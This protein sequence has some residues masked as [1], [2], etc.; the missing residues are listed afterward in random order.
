MGACS[1]ATLAYVIYTSGSTGRPKGVAGHAR[2]TS[3][4][5]SRRPSRWFGFGAERRLDAVP[6]LRLRLLG[7][8]DLGGAALRRPAGGR[9]VLGEPLAGGVPR[10]A[11]A[12]A[13]D[14]A[15]PD[16]V[17]V[18]P[19]HRRRTRSGAGRAAGAA[20]GDLRRRGAGAREPGALV[21]APRRRAAAAGQ[22]VR[23][24]RD[25]GARDLA[26]DHGG[27][28]WTAAGSADRP[29]DPGSRGRT[30]RPPRPA[31]ADR[32]A[33][34]DLRRR[35]GRGPRLSRPAGADG[36]ALR[37]GPVR[38]TPGARL[39]RSGDL[40]RLAA[41]RRAG[42]PGADRP[43]GEDPRLPH[44]AGG[45]RGGAERA[46]WRC[47]EAV[48]LAREDVRARR[49]WWPTSCPA[50]VAPDVRPELRG[51]PRRK[52]AGLHGAGGLRRAARPAADAP[53]A[54]WTGARCR[55]P[56]SRG[57]IWGSATSRPGPRTEEAP[58]GD[59]AAGAGGRAG[60][61]H[62][63]FFELGGDSILAIQIV[64][65]ANRRGCTSRPSSSSSIR[66]SRSW[67][68]WPEPCWRSPGSAGGGGTGALDADPRWFRTASRSASLEPGSAAGDPSG[69]LHRRVA[70]PL[71]GI[72]RAA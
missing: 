71:A 35:R 22:H 21:R 64:A 7:L 47:G 57:R 12:R 50:R 48:V 43:P 55:R 49:G 32:R 66:R 4:G 45:D 23:H 5:C 17:G 40:A 70:G 61:P 3:R 62:D 44:R 18:P 10:A 33:G 53:T 59:L 11:G 54:R 14:G 67:R 6:L 56:G 8:G 41:R 19:A 58:G 65:Q 13:G 30:A 26:A 29:A 68:L 27:R 46:S 60:R 28:T 38:R 31:G 16:A 2:A 15:Q 24:H 36:G 1:E 9:A 34:R 63:N 25:D 42:V 72:A 20:L 69:G 52:P 37:P 39:Y 51:L